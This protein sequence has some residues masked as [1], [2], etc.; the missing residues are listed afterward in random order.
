MKNVV[1]LFLCCSSA[2]TAIIAM[3][4]SAKQ[5]LSQRRKLVLTPLAIKKLEVGKKLDGSLRGT[6]YAQAEYIEGEETLC[7]LQ[8][9]FKEYTQALHT[10]YQELQETLSEVVEQCKQKKTWTKEEGCWLQKLFFL[11]E[12]LEDCFVQWSKLGG[13]PPEQLKITREQLLAR[14]KQLEY[15]QTE[16]DQGQRAKM[17]DDLFERLSKEN[18]E[19]LS[20]KKMENAPQSRPWTM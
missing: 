7:H 11:K 1:V 12:Q 2:S 17:L 3:Q 14:L 18:F 19:D 9:Q 8:E 15:G 4:D 10:D 16:I 5:K 20:K 13:V 6:E